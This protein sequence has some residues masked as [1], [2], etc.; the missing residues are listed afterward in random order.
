VALPLSASAQ[1]GEA[2]TA[3]EE[4]LQEPAP[5][6]EATP[7]EPALQHELD[8]A[9]IQ[10]ASPPA[11]TPDDYTLEELELRKR[12]AAFGLIAPAALTVPGVTLLVLGMKGDCEAEYGLVDN[13]RCRR[14]RTAGLTLTISGTVGMIVGI[15]LAGARARTHRLAERDYTP[16]VPALQ[17]Q[18]DDAG[19]GVA[20]RPPRTPDGYTLEEADLRVKRAKIGLGVSALAFVAGVPLMVVG[21]VGGNCYQLCFFEPCPPPPP[22]CDAM[23]V[24]GAVLLGGGAIGMIATGILL[25]RRKRDRRW[26][27]QA[28]YGT[29]RRVQWDLALSRLVF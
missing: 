26:L 19:A 11:R 6:S 4:N 10:V 7:E 14:L 8:E 3:S 17:L 22:A 21:T 16:E 23:M 5:P 13:D 2:A 9:G 24:S 27:G 12:R 25:R 29:P 15:A 1:A 18:L 28:H 20:P